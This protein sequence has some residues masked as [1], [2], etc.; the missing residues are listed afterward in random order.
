MRQRF[1]LFAGLAVL[2]ALS[3]TGLAVRLAGLAAE[4]RSV[5]TLVLGLFGVALTGTGLAYLAARGLRNQRSGAGI[6]DLPAA[7]WREILSAAPV[8]L[9]LFGADGR[10]VSCNDPWRRLFPEPE[11]QT[12]ALVGEH[13]LEDGTWVLFGKAALA[14]GGALVSATDLTDERRRADEMRAER[15]KMHLILSSAGAW[16]W[17]T[18]V[19]HRFSSVVP[20]RAGLGPDDLGW[21]IGRD[22]AELAAPAEGASGVALSSC[23]QDMQQH[24]RL[25]DVTLTLQDGMRVHPVRLSGVPR[26]GSNGSFLGYCGIGVFEAVPARASAEPAPP[27]PVRAIGSPEASN[28]RIL[29]VDDSRTNRMLGLSILK[30][31]GYECDAAEDGRQAVEAVRGGDYDLVLMDIWMPSMDGIEATGEIRKLPEPVGSIPIVAMTAHAGSKDR[32]RCIESGMDDHVSKPVDRRV[33]SAV[34][35][36][37]L[38]PPN[39]GEAV[40]ASEPTA[41]AE[42]ALVDGAILEQLR[43]DAGPSLVRELIAA[44]MAET[45]ERLLR[46]RSALKSGDFGS[47]VAE[48]HPMKSSCETF[49]ALR[50]QKLVERIESAA[51]QSDAGL[52]SE[53]LDGLPDLVAQSWGEFALAGYPPPSS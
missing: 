12:G 23:T 32:Q 47:V 48:A 29:L 51:V 11:T 45:D 6:G 44:F 19:L 31:M 39:G 50:L 26:L 38:G 35:Q 13:R 37:L 15:E 4:G 14:G 46:M 21:M 5:L 27:V 22:L 3:S 53:L 40:G 25:L 10:L 28:R 33:L 17:E 43:S 49:G 30:K 24:R 9:A 52:A 20:V 41:S 7:D 36:R 8:G 18:D 16:I 34:L 1:W 2:F 42:A